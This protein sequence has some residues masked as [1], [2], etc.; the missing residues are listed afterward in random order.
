M[1]ACLQYNVQKIFIEKQINSKTS[2]KFAKVLNIHQHLQPMR[3]QYSSH[4]HE[5]LR[6]CMKD[7]DVP[8]FATVKFFFSFS[9]TF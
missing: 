8:K 2:N 1:P 6:S 5:E 7:E 9:V 3:Q 4:K